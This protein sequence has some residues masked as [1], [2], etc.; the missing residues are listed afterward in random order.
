MARSRVV[1]DKLEQEL[2]AMHSAENGGLA[3]NEAI[4]KDIATILSEMNH[5]GAIDHST[6]RKMS[7]SNQ[8]LPMCTLKRTNMLTCKIMSLMVL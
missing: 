8:S 3:D 7:N 2:D 5:L 1:M 4:E 6:T